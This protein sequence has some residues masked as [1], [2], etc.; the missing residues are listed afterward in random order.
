M[1]SR[2]KVTSPEKVPTQTERNR[3]NK[4]KLSYNEQK[5]LEKLPALLEQIEQDIATLQSEI[6]SPDF[7]NQ[8]HQHTSAKLQELAEKEQALEDAFVRWEV[9]EAKQ[10]G[11]AI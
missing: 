10:K 8:E 7:F 6:A 5:E 11:I 1:L 3:N 4:I 2:K 9:L